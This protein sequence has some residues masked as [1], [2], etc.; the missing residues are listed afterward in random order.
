MGS[1]TVTVYEGRELIGVI[2]ERGGVFIATA[3]PVRTPVG[4]FDSRADAADAI[5]KFHR[6]E[7]ANAAAS[8]VAISRK[9]NAHRK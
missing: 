4:L 1:G 8:V 9:R 5:S 7:R 3:E 2:T 6:G